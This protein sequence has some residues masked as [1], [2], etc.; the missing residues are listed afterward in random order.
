MN[1]LT[2][3]S[4]NDYVILKILPLCGHRKLG[5][6]KSSEGKINILINALENGSQDLWI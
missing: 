5:L 4:V 2:H 1:V 6:I 3:T